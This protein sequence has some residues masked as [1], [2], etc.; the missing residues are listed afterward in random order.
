MSNF[1]RIHFPLVS[2]GCPLILLQG[3]LA[4]CHAPNASIKQPSL[5][6]FLNC[7]CNHADCPQIPSGFFSPILVFSISLMTSLL[8]LQPNTLSHVLKFAFSILFFVLSTKE[9]VIHCILN[10]IVELLIEIAK[11]NPSV[12]KVDMLL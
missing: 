3:P 6:N 9:H 4:S 12:V 10:G 5:D 2:M 11:K 7:C 1:L 8:F